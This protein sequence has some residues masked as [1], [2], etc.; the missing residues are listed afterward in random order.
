MPTINAEQ[1]I[2]SENLYL[3]T[4]IIIAGSVITDSVRNYQWE[5]KHVYAN[6]TSNWIAT[7]FP[8]VSQEA[9]SEM[10]QIP[11]EASGRS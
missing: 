1:M 3:V 4:I 6:V 2:E 5:L 11:F 7:Q 10:H 9:L 8:S